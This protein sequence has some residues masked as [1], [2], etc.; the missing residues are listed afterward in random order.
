MRAGL[1][2]PCA[3]WSGPAARAQERRQQPDGQQ[4]AEQAEAP[5]GQRLLVLAVL[6]C[7]CGVPKIQ[8]GRAGVMVMA[9]MAE[10]SIDTEMVNGEL[11]E[12]LADEAAEERA[13]QQHAC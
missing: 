6:A 5:P 8:A 2:V 1:T 12:E 9:L 4:P 13:G 3:R 10:I 11:A 7:V